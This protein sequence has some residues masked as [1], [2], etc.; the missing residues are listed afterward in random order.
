MVREEQ[1]LIHQNEQSGNSDEAVGDYD[2]IPSELI[3]RHLSSAKFT[4]RS[5]QSPSSSY[6]IG[7]GKSPM[8]K[9]PLSSTTIRAT[10][11]P[12]KGRITMVKEEDVEMGSMEKVGSRDDLIEKSAKSNEEETDGYREENEKVC[13]E[14]QDG[15]EVEDEDQ[16]AVKW[17]G[18]LFATDTDFLEQSKIRIIF[19]D[20]A[21]EPEDAQLFRMPDYTGEEQPPAVVVQETSA[22][23]EF[24]YPS[25]STLQNSSYCMRIFHYFKC[26]LLA[27]FIMFGVFFFIFY[28]LKDSTSPASSNGTNS[29][30][31]GHH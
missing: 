23:C 1:H 7:L 31:T 13:V 28:T 4:G 27:I 22:L 19:K 11:S 12:L 5:G 26:Y 3:Q 29:T 20:N 17:D 2:S 15:D 30:S 9:T 21:I 24:C 10:T 8:A 16:A 14:S 6:S 18:H 25:Q